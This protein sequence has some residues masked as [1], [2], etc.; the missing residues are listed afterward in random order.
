M[1]SISSCN[2]C[3]TAQIFESKFC[4]ECGSSLSEVAQSSNLPESPSKFTS[5]LLNP[6]NRTVLLLTAG[7]VLFTAILFVA[8]NSFGTSVGG[9]SSNDSASEY[10]TGYNRNIMR[11]NGLDVIDSEGNSVT[12]GQFAGDYV[13]FLESRLGYDVTASDIAVGLAPGGSLDSALHQFFSDENAIA[14]VGAEMQ[15]VAG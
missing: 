9:V 12:L 7:G 8:I 6:A 15:N 3:G 1:S 13:A 2:S 14:V 4:P 10:V 5:Y 11:M